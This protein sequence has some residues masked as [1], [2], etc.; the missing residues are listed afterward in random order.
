MLE[1]Q[2]ATVGELF[3][4]VDRICR[5]F[6]SD[7]NAREEIWFRGQS[8]TGWNLQPLLYRPAVALYH[9]N[10]VALI[11]R[12]VALATPLLAS[13]PASDWEWYFLAR[14][15]GLP[16]RLLDW[17]ESLLSAVYFA[18]WD[19]IPPDRLVLDQRLQ[20]HPPAPCF[21][22][23]CPAV[24]ILDAG[25]LNLASLG[26]DAIVVPGGPRSAPYLPVELQAH[27]AADNALPIAIMPPRANARIVAQQGMFTV[28]GHETAPL[29]TMAATRP[30]IKLGRVRLDLSKVPQ[31][32][33]EL[34]VSG[35]HRLSVFPDLDSVATH[36]CWIYQSTT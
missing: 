9:Y 30:E 3:G 5:L 23:D 19:H 8:R 4:E 15:H 21:N 2:A 22:D 6:K 27:N 13:R 11:D 35:V 10:E 12:F 36:V 34:R 29:E 7:F 17:T 32:I 25:S 14:H 33:S 18:L 16:S 1:G 24:W 26:Q 20:D 28:H 31:L